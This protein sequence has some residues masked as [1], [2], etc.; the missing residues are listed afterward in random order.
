MIIHQDC[1]HFRGD[2]PC[3][4]HK[5]H[6]VHCEEC[7]YYDKIKFRILIVKLDAVGDVLRTTCIL[8]GL[9]EKYPDFHITWLTREESIPLFNNNR[10]V[11]CVLD[12]SAESFLRVELED[13]DLVINP[14]ASPESAM[15]AEVSRGKKKAGFGYNER[16]YVYPFNRE[17]QGW[18][19]MGLFDDIKKANTLTYQKIIL[20]MI[21]L[22]PYSYEIIL[23]L[24]AE[25]KEFARVFADKKGIKPGQLK[26]GLNTGAGGRWELKKWTVEGFSRLY[27]NDR[28]K[29][30]GGQDTPIRRA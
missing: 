8:Q 30:P 10:M 18:F 20:D 22:K 17:A 3:R 6:G 7:P 14:D 15:L 16:G 19:E 21:G 24:N 29:P 26:I 1:R 13:Y 28:Q 5:E 12:Y 23:E 27:R 4:P 9:K 2:V 25:E 11:D